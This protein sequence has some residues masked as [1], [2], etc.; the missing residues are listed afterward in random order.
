MG[1]ELAAVETGDEPLMANHPD[2]PA[3]LAL[4]GFDG[5]RAYATEPDA[6]RA[7]LEE[8]LAFEPRGERAWEVRGEE[9]G[10]FYAYDEPPT[11]R[12]ALGSRHCP[13]CRLGVADGRA[14]GLARAR[15]PGRRAA[16]RP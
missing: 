6:S 15:R 10:S 3:E 11:E 8:A 4:Q 12:G 1:L 16:R 9:R 13:S 2:I 14:R 7:F 5:V